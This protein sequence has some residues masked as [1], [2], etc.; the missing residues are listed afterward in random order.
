[1]TTTITTS[2]DTVRDLVSTTAIA[3]IRPINLTITATLLK[4]FTKMYAFFDGVSVDRY[5]TPAGGVLGGQ[6]T[7]NQDG[8]ISATF[9]IPEMTFTTGTK[10]LV[11]LDFN[12]YA[13]LTTAG[14][15]LV[16][17]TAKFSS[18]GTL[19]TY[20]TTETTTITTTIV[21]PPPPPP[22]YD[23]LAQSFFTYGITGGCFITK[24]D[25]Y[26]ST[27]DAT[28]PVWI[29]LREMVNGYPGPRLLS[30]YGIST[31]NAAD[32]LVSATGLVPT[33][34][35]FS[36]LIY[37]Q[38]DKDYCFVVRSNSNKYNVWTSKMGEKSR[39]TGKTVFEQ[40]YMGSLF[41]SENNV[42]WTA[43]QFEDIK[44][45]MYRANFDTTSSAGLRFALQPNSLAVESSSFKTFITSGR[46]YA[47]FPF[48]HGLKVDSKIAVSVDANSTFNGITSAQLNGSFSVIDVISDYI[49]G[50]NVPG[51]VATSTGPILTGGRIKDII[52]EN[53]G[54]GYNPL[55][56]PTISIT[57]AGTNAAATAVIV[58][59]SIS[60]IIVTNEGSGYIGPVT[61]SI[62]APVGSG[63][64]AVAVTSPKFTVTTNRVYHSVT[65]FV[66]HLLPA[67]TSI[68]TTMDTTTGA[69][70]GGSLTHYGSGKVY[71][72]DLNDLNEFDSNLLLASRFN[73]TDIMGGNISCGME[74]LI[75]S[76]NSNVSPVIDLAKTRISFRTNSIN[77]QELENIQSANS[78]GFVTG[79][80]LVG[81]G[82]GY[83]SAPTL[84][85]SGTGTGATATCTISGGI[86]NAITLVTPGTGYYG[87]AKVAFTG[88]GTPTSN[89]TATVALADYNS[90]LKSNYG[91][92]LSRY[93]TKPQRLQNVSQGI[94]T[95]VTAF[96][97][98]N[99]SFEVYIKTSLSSVGLNH[100]QQEW[101]LLSCDIS[102]NKSTT[103]G[104][105]LDY[106][107]YKDTTSPFDIY[108]LKFVLRT[109]TP[110]QPPIINNYRAIIIA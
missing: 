74:V 27:K 40:P 3:F 56:P 11:L 23:P 80:T 9:A 28:L 49:V 93:V 22:N 17:A 64:S 13:V 46:V 84:T 18:T 83:S 44:F 2:V 8:E 63:A 109:N 20:Q 89:A 71:D 57:G 19:Q 36:R 54:S 108:S 6:L 105:Y 101:Q 61:V 43:E 81:G 58:G 10:E 103:P 24:I 39:E 26:F 60:D 104:Q 77:N 86:V 42:T 102:R 41:K 1:M 88:G 21:E 65:P 95:F 98:A 96:S 106:E 4:P 73:E 69:Y 62:T 30:E 32:V 33:T 45:V 53:S 25:L 15:A 38:Q 51:A 87:T 59:G 99:S 66:P 76:T 14:A 29:E 91:R 50:F 70:D 37:L 5:F 79:I 85:V 48:K 110:W 100:D 35:N 12:D 78:S 94:R 67:N 82:S 52:I 16:K 31:M 34:F 107:F 92:A 68:R 55:N 90:E 75:S 97:N 7:T 47:E 72:I